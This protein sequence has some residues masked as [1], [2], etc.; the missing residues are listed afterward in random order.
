MESHE[1]IMTK[2]ETSQK[3][4]ENA[5]ILAW[6]HSHVPPNKCT[7]LSSIDVHAHKGLERYFGNVQTIVVGVDGERN[8]N[9]RVFDLTKKGHEKVA[10]C[11]NKVNNFHDRCADE[12][13]YQT[14]DKDHYKFLP[15]HP[16]KVLNFM[17]QDIE[18]IDHSN[19]NLESDNDMEIEKENDSN[20]ELQSDEAMDVSEFENRKDVEME[21]ESDDN[22]KE[23]SDNAMD[24]DEQHD[25]DITF[26]YQQKQSEQDQK[27]SDTMLAEECDAGSKK[28]QQ[29]DGE[30]NQQKSD[31]IMLAEECLE[32]DVVT[33]DTEFDEHAP[34]NARIV[35]VNG[36]LKIQCLNC[37][38]TPGNI[39]THSK[40]DCATA[41][42]IEVEKK[43]EQLRL[44]LKK[45]QE[46]RR[47]KR[48]YQ[49]NPDK[50]K[51]K[52]R[53]QSKGAYANNPEHKKAQSKESYANNP[54]PKKAQSKAKSKESYANNPEPKK[55]QSKESYA[56]NPEPKKKMSKKIYNQTKKDLTQDEQ[57]IELNFWKKQAQG[58]CY[59]CVSCHRKLFKTSVVPFEKEIAKKVR[60]HNLQYCVTIDEVMKCEDRFWLC[61]SCKN[62]L[63]D[64][65]MPNMCHANG[66]GI[67]KMPKELE[68]LT[69]LELLMIKKK[70]IFI[71]VKEKKSSAMKYM[72]GSIANVAISDSDVLKSCTFLPRME[73]QL[74]TVN[75]AFKRKRKGYC[76]R[77]P[78]LIR[79]AKVNEA[80]FYL[81]SHHPSYKEFP[82]EVLKE[83]QKYMFANLPLIGQLLEDEEKLLNL[84]D[85]FSYLRQNSL[86][87]ELLYP[88]GKRNEENYAKYMDK[89]VKEKTPQN[90][91]SFIH[92]LLDQMRYVI[93]IKPVIS[94]LF[95]L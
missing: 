75:V 57:K 7:K 82:I 89:L 72:K 45:L 71:K 70:L 81:K 6:I 73:D 44:R 64:G 1:W 25:K 18:A 46:S 54:E 51:K 69:W 47:N 87:M 56:A 32:E 93:L 10:R 84:D 74:G 9:F 91:D 95:Y 60:S 5:T 34:L 49:R 14:I 48:K 3:Y 24:Q 12:S 94:H 21:G 36:K 66:L 58:L 78:E 16:L 79:P 11:R 28:S 61:Y 39:V 63:V 19:L 35:D 77:K 15:E 22:D 26:D 17:E 38:K 59:V 85:A 33:I 4:K 42:P 8:T 68:D 31:N 43:I 52:A 65:K 20:S 55:A 27:K 30:R 50:F 29:K 88:H 2:S 83:T 67:S 62:N 86:L 37:K 92:A 90:N 80:L 41:F 40:K 76:Y 53:D 13:L 23:I